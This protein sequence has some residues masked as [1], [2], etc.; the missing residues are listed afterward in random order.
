MTD[1]VLPIVSPK[2]CVADDVGSNPTA[3]PT[4]GD[5]VAMRLS[6][7]DLMKGAL[8]ATVI[9]AAVAPLT[10]AASRAHAQAAGNS[11]PSFNFAELI[12]G[13]DGKHSVAE[14][15]DADILIRWGDKVL[16]DAPE[17][18]LTKQTGAGQAK[19]FGYNSDYI[20]FVPLAGGS[21]Q[22]LLCINHE[23]AIKALMFP[24]I[25][26]ESS[27]TDVSKAL[28]KDITEVEIMAHG[29]SILEVKRE[30]GK[31]RIVAGSKYARRITGETE[32][33]ISGPAA[34]NDRMQ[35]SYDRTGTKA[36]GMLGNSS[37]GTTPWGTWLSCEKN[38]NHYF[39]GKSGAENSS[40]IKA[41]R[42]YGT[43][44]EWYSWDQHFQ[45]FDYN[46]E[47][48]E[49]NRF[50]WVVEID[51]SDPSSLPVKRTA[52]GRFKHEGAAGVV[53]KDDR[54]VV[55][56]GDG[57]RY[58]YVYK[59]VTE[60]K[61]DARNRAANRDLL[62]KGTLYVAK[63]NAD[64]TG[65]WLPLVHGS[66]PLTADN[67]FSD[68]GDVLIHA[69]MAADL[70]GA[71]KMDRP[72]DI[73]ANPK[74]GKVYVMLGNN[75]R[76]KAEE[77]DAANP[78]AENK[79]GHIIEMLP[80]SGDHAATKF[81]WE[82]LVK[83]GNPAIATVGAS[84]NPATSK[85]GWFGMPDNCTVDVMGRLWIAT[86]GN[87]LDGTGRTDGLWAMETEGPA[88]GTSKLFFRCPVGAEMCGP[89]FTPDAEALFVAVQH[90]GA[91]EYGQT[92][93]TFE[94]PTTRWPDFKDGLPPRPSIVVITKKGGG[95]I[96]V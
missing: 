2:C 68:Q 88:R 12:A 96:A 69:R 58:E 21:D 80:D 49:A 95:K 23:Y 87:T 47:P 10:I 77:V 56:L 85:D 61:V 50:G 3:N 4:M 29:G 33:R 65:E 22:A 32:M 93:S 16:A 48:H 82:I 92:P 34:G 79:F 25:S 24:G 91:S 57:E 43:P 60:G 44:G 37:G 81:H 75:S 7:R 14:G 9:G 78:R 59:F 83:C 35:T 31:W 15:Y 26:E 5:V 36:R 40:D 30:G 73:E 76:R 1:F 46:N 74:T 6:R 64:G 39:S 94:K 66:G 19:Q 62:D 11:T 13:S 42:R 90:P 84:F 67:R 89:R 51:P 27:S 28:T 72:E 17:F 55:Y 52:L 38:F 86:G 63:Y 71:T 70:L 41:L 20:G 8:A 54:Y 53:N 18:D 45:R